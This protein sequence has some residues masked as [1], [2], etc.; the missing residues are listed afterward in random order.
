MPHQL[1]GQKLTLKKAVTKESLRTQ[2]Q[3]EKETKLFISGEVKRLKNQD[4][5]KYFGCFGK[6][7]DVKLMPNKTG[8]GMG[9][10]VFTS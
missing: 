8:S 10:V 6:V 5:K 4:V 7:V 3:E 1:F 2:T 9:C